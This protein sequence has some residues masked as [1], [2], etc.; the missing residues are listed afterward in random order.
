MYPHCSSIRSVLIMVLRAL[1][2][3]P[4]AMEGSKKVNFNGDTIEA[5]TR[6]SASKTSGTFISTKHANS[7]NIYGKFI[8]YKR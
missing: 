7:L 8:I 1:I 2:S 5:A 3:L 4:E 6:F